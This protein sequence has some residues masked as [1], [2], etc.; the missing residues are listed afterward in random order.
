MD[1]TGCLELA[2]CKTK[3][4]SHLCWC[5]VAYVL[6]CQLFQECGL[7]CI[8]QAQEEDPHL[9]VWGAFQFTQD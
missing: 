5:D 9:L 8:I 4:L 7:A 2:G 3:G 1:Y 6:R